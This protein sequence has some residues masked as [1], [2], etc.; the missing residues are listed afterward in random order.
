MYAYTP[1]MLSQWLSDF[2]LNTRIG[3]AAPHCTGGIR[4]LDE[5]TSPLSG[6]CLYIGTAEAVENAVCRGRI[7]AGPIMLLSSGR[8]T[9]R[10][11]PQS[12]TL[13][14]TS[15]P[16]LDLYNR[17]Q[18]HVHRFI[19]WDAKLQKAVYNNS[20]LQEL[21]QIAAEEIPTTIT[22]VNTGYKLLAA[23]YSDDFSEPT[24]EE[25]RTNGY[26]SFETIN[27][28][29]HER[30][31]YG[32]S[33]APSCEYVAAKSGNYTIVNLIRLKDS[34][35]AR[36]CV[37]LNGPKPN[38]CC[39]DLCTVVA[40]YIAEHMFSNH[41]ME[42]SSNAALGSLVADLIECRL[43]D[44]EELEQRLKQV[45]LAV[46]KYYHV[47]VVEFATGRDNRS[48]IPWG[49]IIGQL[50]QVFRYSSIT[51]YRGKIVLLVR[52]T[53]RG[54]LL[55]F[56]K[57]RLLSILEQYNGFLSIGNTS[58][59][60]T[61]L[62]PVYHQADDALRLGRVMDPGKRIFYYEE[63][64]MYQIIEFAAESALHR[65]GSRNLVHLCNNEIVALRLYDKK[66]G[67]NLLEFMH[68]YLLHE[69]NVTETAKA[70][71]I[72]RN[73][74]QYKIHKIEEII[75]SSLDS[76]ILRERLMFSYHVLEYI[77]RYRN[78]DVLELKRTRLEDL[79]TG[80]KQ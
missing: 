58:E 43:T 15:L 11:L 54:N 38:R 35:A 55:T 20:G 72:H 68:V 75:G 71:Y 17:T 44:R 14:E 62:S 2:V 32:G 59:F 78:E 51:T 23:V 34:I 10:S 27:E 21:V 56:D 6:E 49:Y 70:L 1:A 8:C 73:T 42:Y 4:L 67:S 53:K 37:V 39:S 60:L 57:E 66:N 50:E 41:G 69:R 31:L 19:A 36:L 30:P 26:L 40:G 12:M 29:H 25:L 76:P 45:H 65:L 5:S 80:E 47:V 64:S 77:T 13:I 79:P 16:L 24:A 63:Y 61:S 3:N 33:D 52:K 9:I 46:Y 74:A 18:E 28:I 22:L 48:S 7:P